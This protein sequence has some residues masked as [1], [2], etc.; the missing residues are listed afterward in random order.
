MNAIA[1]AAVSLAA[2]LAAYFTYARFLQVR[3]FKL[4]PD[5][6]VPSR[7]FQDGIDFVPTRPAILFSH[8]FVS[9]AGLGPILGPAIGVIWGWLPAMLWVVF[10]TIFFGAVHDFGALV[11]SLRSEGRPIGEIVRDT[12]GYRAGTLFMLIICFLLALAMGV[13]AY[14]V[15]VLFTSF[16]PESV[17]P[18]GCL[19]PIAVLTGYLIYRLRVPVTAATVLGLILMFGA[20][21]IGLDYPVP[22]YRYFLDPE[23]GAAVSAL[24]AAPLPGAAAEALREAGNAAGAQQVLAAADR[25]RDCWIWILLAYAFLAS[26]LPV[27][28]LLQPRDYLNSFQL[29]AG[30]L[31]LVA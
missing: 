2:F 13:F 8:H 17:L 22:L 11:I 3:I 31:L 12:V 5:E 27:W 29:Y 1:L 15:A 9:I 7:R 26:V 16:Y 21:R 6:T 20:I 25:A 28:V 23:V 30:M 24:T 4:L 14:L 19:M 10:G 18:V